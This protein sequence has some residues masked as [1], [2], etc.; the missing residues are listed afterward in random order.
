MKIETTYGSARISRWVIPSVCLMVFCFKACKAQETEEPQPL[1]SRFSPARVSAQLDS[2]KTY[3]VV[4]MP[5]GSALHQ[6]LDTSGNI[7]Q[8]SGQTINFLPPPGNF[9][10]VVGCGK[11]DSTSGEIQRLQ[12]L[13]M[14]SAFEAQ[15]VIEILPVAAIVLTREGVSVPVV[16]AIPVDSTMQTIRVK[17]FVDLITEYDAARYILQQWFINY[18]GRDVFGLSGWRDEHYARQ[19]TADWKLKE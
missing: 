1:F 14:M 11:V 4:E 15:S 6:K 13:T 5:A 16:I 17:N 12:V 8:G 9:G 10:V 19:L 7:V 3:M 2:T 18:Q